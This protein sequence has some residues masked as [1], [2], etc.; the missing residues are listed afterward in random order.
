MKS[1]IKK[2]SI[3]TDPFKGYEDLRRSELRSLKS[4]TLRE[5]IRQTEM[6]LKEAERWTK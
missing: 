5:A 2:K 3:Q 1:K 6:L 4:L